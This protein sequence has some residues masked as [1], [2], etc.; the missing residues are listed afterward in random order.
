MFTLTGGAGIVM[1]AAVDVI[2]IL[3][4]L[5][6]WKLSRASNESRPPSDVEE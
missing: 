6:V 2:I 1:I 3:G 5:D 4:A